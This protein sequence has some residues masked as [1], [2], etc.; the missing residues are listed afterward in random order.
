MT[1]FTEYAP[2]TPCWVDVSSPDIP[3]S[4]A[5]YAGVFGWEASA[6]P[7]PEAGGYGMFSKDGGV[8]AGFGPGQ[9]GAP[10]TWTTYV[11]TDDADAV[12]E[13]IAAAGGTVLAGPMDVLDA[14][15][16]VFAADEQGATFG[17]WQAGTHHGAEL[18][19]E[20]G[21]LCWN[22]LTTDVPDRAEAFYGAVFGWRSEPM[23]EGYWG[24]DAGAGPVA[25]IMARPPE[26]P[27]DVPPLWT[28]YIAVDSLEETLAKVTELG[29]SVVFGPLD[30]PFGPFAGIADP[31]GAQVSAIE[32]AAPEEA[33]A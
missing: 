33:A 23:G 7:R 15:R 22:E 6:D 29:G 3:A 13:R 26:M 1:R 17:V 27:A 2:G 24:Q 18:A 20:P 8:V 10:P 31:V 19:N 9:P 4:T 16:M 28:A 14:G 32:L 12:A 30:S 25:G 5:F 11:A 21:T